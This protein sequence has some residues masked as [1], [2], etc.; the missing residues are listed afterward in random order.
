MREGVTMM[1]KG[2][3]LLHVE[4]LSKSYDGK[5][6]AL[7]NVSLSLDRGE[8]VS[9]IGSSGAG[10]STLLRCVNRLI[11]PTKGSI[12]FNGVEMMTLRG[13]ALRKQRR[14]ISMVFQNYNLVLRSSVIQNVLQ[15]RLGYKSTLAG[16][17]GLFNDEDK[18][19]AFEMLERVGMADFAYMRTD[20]LSGGQKQRVG[21]ARALVQ[22]P[23]LILAD[24]PIASLDPKTSRD[25]LKLLRSAAN[26]MGIACLVS[27]HQVEFAVEFSDRI[28]GLSHGRECCAGVPAD[29]TDRVLASLYED[30]L[31]D[32]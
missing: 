6:F 28:F 29:F 31:L 25:V 27:L 17:L 8:F 9:I 4:D 23:L 1:G 16:A 15:G 24:E 30:D 13:R 22:Q 18:K 7:E 2:D 14:R 12:R 5:T 3:S 10:K 32:D 21:I 11:E 26:D 20:Q 19:M